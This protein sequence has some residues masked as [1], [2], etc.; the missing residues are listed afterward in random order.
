MILF[1]LIFANQSRERKP[2]R[3]MKTQKEAGFMMECH[4]RAQGFGG[5]G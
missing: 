1:L 2:R 5:Q 4:T 3:S